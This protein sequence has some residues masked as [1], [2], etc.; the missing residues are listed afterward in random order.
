MR[1]ALALLLLTISL[2]AQTP[3]GDVVDLVNA[4]IAE[5][6]APVG[7][8]GPN[9]GYTTALNNEGR[10]VVS[11]TPTPYA[12]PLVVHAESTTLL[13]PARG[14]VELVIRNEGKDSFYLPL[15]MDPSLKPI[16]FG[17]R[18][19]RYLWFEATVRSDR[20][21]AHRTGRL[22]S[23]LATSQERHLLLTMTYGSE[24]GGSLREVRPKESVRV[25]APLEFVSDDSLWLAGIREAG[26]A[27]LDIQVM[28]SEQR[29]EDT[30]GRISSQS[31]RVKS[32]N[33]IPLKI[34]P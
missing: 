7:A 22:P 3:S 2:C 6:A 14:V 5:K 18:G 29:L 15:S 8:T 25:K 9:S 21:P 27:A 11:P 33:T 1:I 16:L 12:L 4:P 23:Y 17:N 24:S 32:E 30:S 20:M 28:I 10:L 34:Q 31:E 13:N 26:G 19:R